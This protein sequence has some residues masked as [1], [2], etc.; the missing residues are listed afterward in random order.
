METSPWKDFVCEETDCQADFDTRYELNK[1]IMLKHPRSNM[2]FH[3]R[4]EDVEKA[5]VDHKLL[6]SLS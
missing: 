6:E 4:L 5:L 2:G 3:L 1:H